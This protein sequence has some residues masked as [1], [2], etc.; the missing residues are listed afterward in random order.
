MDY[1]TLLVLVYFFCLENVPT[2][3]ST[4]TMCLWSVPSLGV[5]VSFRG[6]LQTLLFDDSDTKHQGNATQYNLFSAVSPP[7]TQSVHV[8]LTQA[9]SFF[10]S[11][12]SSVTYFLFISIISKLCFWPRPMSY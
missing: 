6:V 7:E 9:L 5:L 2:Y 10:I 8:A 11:V 4:E 1:R 3:Y 12:I